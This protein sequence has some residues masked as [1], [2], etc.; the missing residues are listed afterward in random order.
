MHQKPTILVTGASGYIGGMLIPQ[1]IDQ[2]FVV[3]CMARRPQLIGGRLGPGVEC[4]AGDALQQETLKQPLAGIEIAYYLI[5]SMAGGET[6]F[7][8]RDRLAAEN[9]AAVA[10]KSGIK[11]IIYLGGLGGQDQ[12]LSPH[13]SSRQEVGEIL[14]S[15]GIPVTEFRAAVIVGSG[16][17]SFEIIR[18][19]TERLPVMICPRWLLSK[20]Q[21]IAVRDV[22]SYL[23]EAISVT[24]S[25]GE[26]IEI[27][28]R[29][30]I[31]FADMI[32]QYAEVR[33]LKRILIQVPVL[34]PRLSSYWIDLVT[35]IPAAISHSLVEGLRSD[36]ICHSGKAKEIFPDIH[37]L[38]Y[39]AA[40]REALK[41]DSP[42]LKDLSS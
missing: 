42:A 14:R 31:T 26:I 10:K 1:L 12:Q 27:G 4:V 38:G 22:L 8:A 13:L 7:V 16:S 18:Y 40:V 6:G 34:T 15:S 11:R 30:V 29:D 3:R 24:A 28:G 5:H 33:G 19:L 21:P 2:G 20:C 17:L 36:V 39:Q 23:A 25:T 9:F 37:P 35:P 41:R 32:R